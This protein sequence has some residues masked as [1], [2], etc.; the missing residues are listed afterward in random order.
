MSLWNTSLWLVL[1]DLNSRL[2]AVKVG[3]VF[4]KG[5]SWRSMMQVVQIT[6]ARGPK[7]LEHAALK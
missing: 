7:T 2:N 4:V 1:R 6:D 3:E 5:T